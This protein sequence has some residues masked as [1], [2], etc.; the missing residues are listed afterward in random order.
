[1]MLSAKRL[2]DMVY[3]RS[4]SL[5][6][7]IYV[8]WY[9]VESDRH[10][11]LRE[12]ESVKESLLLATFVLDGRAFSNANSILLDL[13]DLLNHRREYVEN[14]FRRA[15]YEEV[16]RVLLI[17]RT[18]LMLP[19]ISSPMMLPEWFP[20]NGGQVVDTFIEDLT[21]SAEGPL[22][23]PEAAVSTVCRVLF[24]TEIVLCRRLKA[25]LVEDP[26][27][28]SVFF[29][30]LRNRGEDVNIAEF[31]EEAKRRTSLI[32]NSSGFRP[33]ASEGYFIVGRIL[34][35][36]TK[37]SPDSL[38]NAARMLAKALDLGDLPHTSVQESLAAVVLRS[39]VR[40][41][42]GGARLSRSFLVTLYCACQFVTAAA[43]ADDYPKYSLNLL[44]SFS[45]NITDCIREF[46]ALIGRNSS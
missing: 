24:E 46:S 27:S 3:E 38:L 40:E 41:R 18:P 4:Q 19:Q 6:E 33:S 32:K 11:F 23:C 9:S 43:H 8:F 13:S 5:A 14:L 34:R 7:P 12:L 29:D 39:T 42:N 30:L 28:V 26:D 15:N 10:R 31:F 35:L 2:I 44:D 20:R 16:L 25:R 37:M 22:N 1:M 17:S 36:V 21:Y 45:K